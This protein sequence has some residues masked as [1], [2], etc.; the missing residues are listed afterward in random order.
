MQIY[1]V[2]YKKRKLHDNNKHTANF[3][4]LKPVGYDTFQTS[5]NKNYY[6]DKIYFSEKYS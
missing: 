4:N 3:R 1:A 6:K 2:N 5:N